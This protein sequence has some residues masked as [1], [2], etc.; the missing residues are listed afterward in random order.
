MRWQRTRTAQ[1][2]LDRELEVPLFECLQLRPVETDAEVLARAPDPAHPPQPSKAHEL[3]R[4]L[5][6]RPLR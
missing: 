5:G 1:Q 4:S 6:Q 3:F 2:L